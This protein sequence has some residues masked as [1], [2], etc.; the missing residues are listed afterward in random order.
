VDGVPRLGQGAVHVWRI[1]VRRSE[2]VMRRLRATLTRD[3]EERAARFR[4]D[5]DR[6][7]FE[8]TRGA[9]RILTGAYLGIDPADVRF[10]Y[11]AKGKPSTKGLSF[12]VSHAG[13][14]AVAAFARCGRVGVDVEVMDAAVE[15]RTLARRF[16]SEP[17]NAVLEELEGDA[18][19]RG[20]YACWTRK[21]AFVKA[22]GEGVSLLERVEVAVHGPARV[23]SV[24][25]DVGAAAG[26]SMADLAAGEGYAG[27]VVADG[28]DVAVELW[29][30]PGLEVGVS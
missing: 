24:D 27:A 14:L 4:F 28:A 9:L 12:N 23:L 10:D 20:F 26:W 7:S 15:L 25:G 8:C 17:E 21:E 29:D 3:E 19:V 30:W 5:R 13:D 2:E 16:F 1:D 22:V 11:D 6:G 18:L